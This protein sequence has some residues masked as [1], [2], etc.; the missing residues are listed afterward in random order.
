MHAA[1]VGLNVASRIDGSRIMSNAKKL[2][3]LADGDDAAALLRELAD[4]P[5][6]RIRND[7]GE[8]LFLYSLYRG[9]SA[10]VDALQRRGG[11]TLH[12]AAAAGDVARI[13]VLIGQAPWTIQSLSADGWTALHLAAFV[14]RDAAT[15]RLL[16]LGADARQWGRAFETNLAIH[17]ACAGRRLGKGALAKLVAAT[18][19]PDITPKHGYTPLMEA[20]ANGYADAIDVLLAAGADRS[21]KHPDG[22][23]AADFAREKGHKELSERL[24]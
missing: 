11:L 22:N 24:S 8:T 15:I 21:R 3:T 5:T 1:H 18:G 20:A 4:T 2:F 14:G 16:E 19:D 23:T 9:K 13:E 17:A 10:C 7:S 12:E 6:H